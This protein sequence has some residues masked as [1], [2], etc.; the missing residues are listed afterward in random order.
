MPFFSL[1]NEP[2]VPAELRNDGRS[3]PDVSSSYISLRCLWSLL[4][5]DCFIEGGDFFPSPI[6][7][8]PASLAESFGVFCPIFSRNAFF[9]CAERHGEK[10]SFFFLRIKAFPP[11][12]SR[13]PLF[14]PLSLPGRVWVL[15]DVRLL[16]AMTAA[17]PTDFPIR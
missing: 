11:P 9:S 5:N 1:G 12:F 17:S 6:S 13:R 7:L 3:Y 2:I 4:F 8:T 16:M 10:L 15:L 14:L